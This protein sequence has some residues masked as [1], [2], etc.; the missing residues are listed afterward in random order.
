MTRVERIRKTMSEK[1]IDALL[2]LDELNQHYLSG[3]AFTDG[4]L[5]ITIER[6]ISSPISDTM[7]WQ[8][9]VLSVILR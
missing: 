4:A 2:V 6:R 8:R 3:F 9:R 5:L 7:K 1:G